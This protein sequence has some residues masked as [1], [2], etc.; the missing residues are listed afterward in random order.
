MYRSINID[1]NDSDDDPCNGT[2]DD[3]ATV[4]NVIVP[5]VTQISQ[6]VINKCILETQ[7]K[8]YP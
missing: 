3:G 5:S 1:N 6:K 4:L 7:F 2:N 8:R